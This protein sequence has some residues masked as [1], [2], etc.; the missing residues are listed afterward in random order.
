M[1]KELWVEK[2]FRTHSIMCLRIFLNANRYKIDYR[3]R[4]PDCCLG[5]PLCTGKTTCQKPI[6][7]L[8]VEKADVLYI[9]AS[10][11]N[12]VEMISKKIPAFSET[13]ALGLFLR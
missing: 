8:N 4:D 9:N 1:A 7:E 11:D 2:Y 13:M 6:N 12:G 10:P 5:S 3:W